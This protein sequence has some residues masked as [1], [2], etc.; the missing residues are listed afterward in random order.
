MEIGADIEAR[1]G[2]W[3]KPP[4]QMALM[5]EGWQRQVFA[6]AE[7]TFPIA[8]F[9][10]KHGANIHAKDKEGHRAINVKG[11][12]APLD[13]K[14]IAEFAIQHGALVGVTK[15]EVERLITAENIGQHSVKDRNIVVHQE[16]EKILVR[17]HLK[18][19]GATKYGKANYQTI[20]EMIAYLHKTIPQ[21]YG[22]QEMGMLD[23]E[24]A[25]GQVAGFYPVSQA[26]MHSTGAKAFAAI[27]A[28]NKASRDAGR[29]RFAE[30]QSNENQDIECKVVEDGKEV[31]I[32]RPVKAGGIEKGF[33]DALAMLVDEVFLGE[34]GKQNFDRLS[35][36]SKAIKGEHTARLRS[37]ENTERSAVLGSH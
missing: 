1:G 7:I 2:L 22:Y 15:E 24:T 11:E 28:V 13:H 30:G 17:T 31:K 10:L 4:L 5:K 36:A 6:M 34:G 33:D 35:H 12:I 18:A 27:R 16:A 20:L 19:S 26:L 23:S 21:T 37:Q 3:G 32:S 29:L 25:K 9:L 14:A 8:T